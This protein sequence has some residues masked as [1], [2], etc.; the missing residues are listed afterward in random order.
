MI[1]RLIQKE[2]QHRAIVQTPKTIRAIRSMDNWGISMAGLEPPFAHVLTGRLTQREQRVQL[3]FILSHKKQCNLCEAL[4][5]FQKTANSHNTKR[6][7]K[8]VP[9]SG[10]FI[11]SPSL[12]C[13]VFRLMM[14]NSGFY[15]VAQNVC[16]FHS[17]RTEYRVLWPLF[18]SNRKKIGQVLIHNVLFPSPGQ[19]ERGGAQRFTGD[20][21]PDPPSHSAT[22]WGQTLPTHTHT[23]THSHMVYNSHQYT[24]PPVHIQTQRV[25][26]GLCTRRQ[27]RALRIASE[28]TQSSEDS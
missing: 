10:H 21:S 13:N 25:H 17:P 26:I 4:W 7:R 14:M 18:P 9:T 12:V 15:R 16:I 24:C 22:S 23:H 8:R 11:S 20:P 6:I 28:L 5:G 1:Q 2:E 3:L 27:L 19:R